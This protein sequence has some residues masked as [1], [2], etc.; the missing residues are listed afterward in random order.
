MTTPCGLTQEKLDAHVGWLT[1]DGMCN[2]LFELENG[3]IKTGCGKPYA[4]HPS[5]AQ[6]KEHFFL[7]ISFLHRA[8][9]FEIM[10]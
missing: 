4:S 5:S 3:E 2:A 8:V 7:L 6:G 9:Y 1:A 10:L